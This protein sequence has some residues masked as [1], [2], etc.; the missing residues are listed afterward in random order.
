V[1][2]RKSLKNKVPENRVY[3]P[4]KILCSYG[5]LQCPNCLPKWRIKSN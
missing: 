3:E 4:I 1:K 5:I 2:M